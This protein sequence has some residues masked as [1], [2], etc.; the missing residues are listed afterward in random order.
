MKLDNILLAIDGHIKVIDFGTSAEKIRYG[1][2]TNT[3]CG[4]AEFMAP[5]VFRNPFSIF[6]YQKSI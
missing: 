6:G 1:T 5:E 3:F 2:T 4:N